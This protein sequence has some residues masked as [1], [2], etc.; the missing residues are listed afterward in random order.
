M[1]GVSCTSIKL[2]EALRPLP[3]A[4]LKDFEHFKD[5]KLLVYDYL[6]YV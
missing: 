6:V 2:L 4:I 5:L 3:P 1:M